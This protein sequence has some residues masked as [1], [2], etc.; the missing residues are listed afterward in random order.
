MFYN[1]SLAN[2]FG[3]VIPNFNDTV[4]Y[5]NPELWKEGSAHLPLY[6]PEKGGRERNFSDFLPQTVK[7]NLKFSQTT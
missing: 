2:P 3:F 6:T 5:S 1:S 4:D 7:T